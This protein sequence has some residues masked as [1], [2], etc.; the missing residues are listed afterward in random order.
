MGRWLWRE[1]RRSRRQISKE[2]GGESR[3]RVVAS[4]DW[5]RTEERGGARVTGDG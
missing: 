4:L 1:G 2:E 5:E 3:R